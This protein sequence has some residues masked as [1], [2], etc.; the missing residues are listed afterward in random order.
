MGIKN[1]I[2]LGNVQDEEFGE[3]FAH[4]ELIDINAEEWNRI[5]LKSNK[6]QFVRLCGYEPLNDD[7]VNRW[8]R[9]ISK[10][11]SVVK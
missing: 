1:L 10:K 8:V 6:A 9:S 7:E 5:A 3:N 2:K 4:F 11:C